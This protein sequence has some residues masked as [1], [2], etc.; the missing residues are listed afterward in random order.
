[1]VRLLLGG[2]I[3]IHKGG[4]Y[5]TMGIATDHPSVSG[6]NAHGGINM[7]GNGI[8]RCNGVGNTDGD[9]NLASSGK[10]SIS[11]GTETWINNTLSGIVVNN[12]SGSM[13]S[14]SSLIVR[15]QGNGAQL[16]NL[17]VGDNVINATTDLHLNNN[18]KIYLNNSGSGVILDGENGKSLREYIIDL[19]GQY[20]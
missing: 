9:L 1:M 8:S 12:G 17:W 13:V 15:K 10:I 14:L 16:G 5:L 4:Y 2:S 20:G 6:L 3:D 19:I 11:S 7:W 18:G